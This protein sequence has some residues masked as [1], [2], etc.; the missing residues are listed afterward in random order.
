ME[1][2]KLKFK[3]FLMAA[4]RAA[5]EPRASPRGPDLAAAHRRP[6]NC[7]SSDYE[8]KREGRAGG[9]GEAERGEREGEEGR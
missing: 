7:S 1:L 3:Y 4:A 9:E 8:V 5:P 2:P 6:H